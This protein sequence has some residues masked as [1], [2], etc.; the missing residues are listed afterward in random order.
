[1]GCSSVES[2]LTWPRWG[3][4]LDGVVTELSMWERSTGEIGCSLWHTP[5]ASDGMQ[6][7]IIGQN[8][9]FRETSGLPRKY[10]QN[11]TDGSVGLARLVQFPERMWPTPRANKINPSNQACL[12]D[13]Y[14]GNLEEAIARAEPKAQGSLNPLFVCWLMGFPKHWLDVD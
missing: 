7:A 5:T 9:T 2:S 4:L 8:D 6:G 10:N 1:M 3:M 12:R 14:H 13:D 11:G